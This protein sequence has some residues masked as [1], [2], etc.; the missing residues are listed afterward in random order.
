MYDNG[1]EIA[2][3][4]DD[5]YTFVVSETDSVALDVDDDVKMDKPVELA[6]K[7]D[8]AQEVFVAD[9]VQAC[10]ASLGNYTIKDIEFV[11][12]ETVYGYSGPVLCWEACL[13][14]KANYLDPS[15]SLTAG[16]VY[17]YIGRPDPYSISQA[18]VDKAYEHYGMN[19]TYYKKTIPTSDLLD[20]LRANN[21]IELSVHHHSTTK[22]IYHAI[23]LKGMHVYNDHTDF[24]ILDPDF[25]SAE[26]EATVTVKG[27]PNAVHKS[28][29]YKT[30]YQDGRDE[31]KQLSYKWEK[32]RY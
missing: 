14:M 32:T 17:K 21:A 25:T 2:I 11:P 12:N 31:D 22:D 9:P 19:V 30:Q 27:L 1:E 23:L 28:F 4:S 16:D 18:T 7:I 26:G 3:T 15:L 5:G 13:A 10:S 20:E 6:A 29:V 24:Y 8:K